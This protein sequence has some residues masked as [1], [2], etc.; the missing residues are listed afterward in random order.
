MLGIIFCSAMIFSAVAGFICY[1][2]GERQ[3]KADTE[4]LNEQINYADKKAA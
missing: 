1:F 2:R 4:T 3:E